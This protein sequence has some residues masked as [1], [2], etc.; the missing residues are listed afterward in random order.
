[1]EDSSICNDAIAQAI[2]EGQS[3][4]DAVSPLTKFLTQKVNEPYLL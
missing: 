2:A 4:G 3:G 1:V